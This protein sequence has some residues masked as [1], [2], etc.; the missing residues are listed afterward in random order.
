M[1][2][3]AE[4]EFSASN[5]R[6]FIKT[7][8]EK[9]QT[10]WMFLTIFLPDQ[11]WILFWGREALPCLLHV[12][13]W[14]CVFF[15]YNL[16]RNNI[17]YS[18]CNNHL[19]QN[20]VAW[21]CFLICCCVLNILH[22]ERGTVLEQKIKLIFLLKLNEANSEDSCSSGLAEHLPGGECSCLWVR[23]FRHTVI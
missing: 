17:F 4:D 8:K 7:K 21:T 9:D 5:F 18:L 23:D 16:F 19:K 2:C 14:L 10:L 20:Q 15:P 11:S 1:Q 13:G 12:G 22:I 6:E 3:S